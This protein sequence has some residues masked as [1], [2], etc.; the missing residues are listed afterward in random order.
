LK[1]I[2]LTEVYVLDTS[3]CSKSRSAAFDSRYHAE[4]Y[5]RFN[6][7]PSAPKSILIIHSSMLFS[8]VDRE[9]YMFVDCFFPFRDEMLMMQ[10]SNVQVKFQVDTE[11]C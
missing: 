4:P 2:I 1:S 6:K 10:T 11:M 7:I 9:F 8:A 3:L 5:D